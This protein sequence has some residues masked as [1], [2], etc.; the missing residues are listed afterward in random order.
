MGEEI[1]VLVVDDEALVRHAF[2]FFIKSAGGMVVVGEAQDG[3]VAVEMV[4]SVAPDVVLMDIQMPVMDGIDA[5]WLITQEN[6][7]VRVLA[8]TT[9]SSSRHVVPAMRAGASGYLLKDSEPEELVSAIRSVHEGGYVL[10]KDVAGALV[11]AVRDEQPA[12]FPLQL[13]SAELLTARE[14]EVVQLLGEGLS[15]P[16][17]AERLFVSEAT[18]KTHLGRVMQ[19]WKTRDRTQVLIRAVKAGIVRLD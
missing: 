7:D 9:F 15:N 1:K 3:Q 2:G 14:D 18:V 10:S 4:R 12:A 16:E 17:I 11:E 19:K 13:T 8:V 5:T 6:R